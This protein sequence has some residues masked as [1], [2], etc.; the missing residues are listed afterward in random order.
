MTGGNEGSKPDDIELTVVLPEPTYA[1]P[2]TIT[3]DTTNKVRKT[4]KE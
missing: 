3:V 1:K 4:Y 2:V